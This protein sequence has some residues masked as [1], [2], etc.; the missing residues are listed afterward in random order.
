[1]NDLVKVKMYF[2]YHAN[3]KQTYMST[4]Q[5]EIWKTSLTERDNYKTGQ[6]FNFIT[7][8]NKKVRMTKESNTSTLACFTTYEQDMSCY[9]PSWDLTRN[10]IV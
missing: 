7:D 6:S 4:L 5:C 8:N 10:K 2:H 1:M 3:N 9:C